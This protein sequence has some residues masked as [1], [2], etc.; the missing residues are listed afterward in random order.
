MNILLLKNPTTPRDFYQELFVDQKGHNAVFVPLLQHSPVGI[1]TLKTHIANDVNDIDAV[2]VTSHRAVEILGEYASPE[3]LSKPAYTVGP[4]TARCLRELGF[5]DVRGEETGNGAA[6][7]PQLLSDG[8]QRF[9]FYA[10]KVR[11]DTIPNKLREAGRS[12]VEYTVYETVD[13]DDI[14]GRFEKTVS[15]LP[16]AKD[17]WICFFAPSGTAQIVEYL[18]KNPSHGFKIAS[19]GPTTLDYLEKNDIKVDV[20]AKQPDPEHFLEAM[21]SVE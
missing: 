8:F 3:L 7:V 4:A 21:L 16:E 2:I 1:E 14:A 9:A 20:T 5:T 19:I 6:L 12:L 17:N 10:G 11:R 15:A 13:L 18:K